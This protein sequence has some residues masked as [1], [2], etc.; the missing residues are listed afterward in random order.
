MCAIMANV[1]LK[2]PV[3][4]GTTTEVV[5]STFEP[6]VICLFVG[7]FYQRNSFTTVQDADMKRYT[8]AVEK[9][10]ADFEDGRGTTHENWVLMQ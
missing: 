1:V 6:S 5:L 3:T 10:T 8:C 4:A 2:T 9:M 7:R